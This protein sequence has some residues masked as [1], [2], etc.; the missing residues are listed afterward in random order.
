MSQPQ[1]P[2]DNS[3]PLSSEFEDLGLVDATPSTSKS[4]GLGESD[5]TEGEVDSASRGGSLSGSAPQVRCCRA[6]TFAAPGHVHLLAS[7][8]L[9]LSPDNDL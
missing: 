4:T 8:S 7:C 1:S 3:S 2:E 9:C 5:W 6:V